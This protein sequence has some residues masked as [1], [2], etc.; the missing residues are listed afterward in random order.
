MRIPYGDNTDKQYDFSLDVFETVKDFEDKV[1]ECTSGINK[2]NILVDGQK[3][4]ENMLVSEVLKKKFQ[5]Q[6][7]Q[8]TY[9]V[10][11]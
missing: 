11:P 9:D 3:K 6:V 7:N 2:F 5:I 1:K 8:S 10:Y 4:D